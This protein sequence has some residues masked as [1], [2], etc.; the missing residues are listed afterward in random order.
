M[1]VD[2]GGLPLLLSFVI[3]IVALH[4]R[5]LILVTDAWNKLT[6]QVVVI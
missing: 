6:K 3:L 1:V 2:G 4:N 5:V